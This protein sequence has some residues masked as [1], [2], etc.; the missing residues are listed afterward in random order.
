MQGPNAGTAGET[1][2]VPALQSREVTQLH[3]G[4][5]SLLAGVT[6]LDPM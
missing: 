1:P 6:E 2:A 3:F 5:P 4:S